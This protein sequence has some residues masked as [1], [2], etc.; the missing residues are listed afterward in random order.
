MGSLERVGWNLLEKGK[1]GCYKNVETSKLKISVD[2][3]K[4][5]LKFDIKEQGI[6]SD[7]Q[8]NLSEESHTLLHKKWAAN[9]GFGHIYWR[10]P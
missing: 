9:C 5:Y 1:N 6:S 3:S 10:N 2:H 7:M 4:E 8:K